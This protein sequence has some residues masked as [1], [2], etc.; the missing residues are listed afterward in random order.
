MTSPARIELPGMYP[1]QERVLYAPQRFGFIEGSTKSGKTAGCMVWQLSH[2]LLGRPRA[3]HWWVAPIYAQAKIAYNRSLRD[4]E[5]LITAS[6]KSE[7]WIEIAGSRWW[8][9]SGD[10]PDSLYGEEVDSAVLDEASRMDENAWTAVRSTLTTT[11]GPARAIANVKGRGN[12]H[13][14]LCRRAEAGEPNYYYGRLTAQDAVDGGVLHPE[15]LE[16]AAR[17]LPHDVYRELYFCEPA[18]DAHNPFGLAALDAAFGPV[19]DYPPV[20]FGLDLARKR[21]HTVL[22][23]LNQLGQAVVVDRFQLPWNEAYDRIRDTVGVR[24]VLM[25]ATGIGDPIS[26]EL[27]KRRVNVTPYVKTA[28]TKQDL[29]LLLRSGFAEGRIRHNNEI[30][31]MELEHFEYRYGL[32]GGVRYSAPD[33]MHDD[34]VDALGL[35]YWHATHLGLLRP[36]SQLARPSE[37]IYSGSRRDRVRVR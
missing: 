2:I 16:Q 19:D 6:N 35:A 8:F 27:R 31:R 18:D 26:D 30:L 10:N 21:D 12:W 5:Q 17:D 23:G 13:Y 20:V 24:P 15:E 7:L 37:T 14:K 4:F 29:M 36:V 34:C 28:S 33:G 1:K 22:I 25:D 3:N 11:R 32:N 9:K